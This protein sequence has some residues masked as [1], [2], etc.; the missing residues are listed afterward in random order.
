MRRT[1]VL[2][3]FNAANMSN[4]FQINYNNQKLEV[5]VQKE[6]INKKFIIHSGSNTPI[7]LLQAEDSDGAN[8]WLD[9]DKNEPT[10]KSKEI[11]IAIEKYMAE[12]SEEL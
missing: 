8:R 4:K 7:T 12:H 1:L 9:A 11:G 3:H 5:E 6:T 2:H 10:E